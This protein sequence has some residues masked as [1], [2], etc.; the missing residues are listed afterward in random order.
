MA[1]KQMIEAQTKLLQR[2]MKAIQFHSELAAECDKAGLPILA[3]EHDF[4]AKCLREKVD[5]QVRAFRDGGLAKEK[6]E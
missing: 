4:V 5:L 6:S 1:E 2:T 3:R